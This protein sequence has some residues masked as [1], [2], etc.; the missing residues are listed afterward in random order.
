MVHGDGLL[1]KID[2]PCI[3]HCTIAT[4]STGA[5][6]MFSQSTPRQRGSKSVDGWVRRL[7][8]VNNFKEHIWKERSTDR[9]GFTYTICISLCTET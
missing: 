4:S 2:V 8:M 3:C 6:F 7:N 5:F 1:L 9:E